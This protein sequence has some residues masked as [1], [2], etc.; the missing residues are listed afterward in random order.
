MTL[1]ARL[2]R[3]ETL[4]DRVIKVDHAGEYGAICIYRAQRW[5]AHWRAPDMIGELD[6]FLDHE[7][8]HR[9]RFG[10]EL[11]RRNRRRCRSYHLCGLG[12]FILGVVTGMA[13]RGA[14]AATTVAIERVVLRHMSAQIEALVGKDE[15]A[16]ALLRQIIV[17]ERE[18]HDVS[19]VRLNP[20]F[21]P[22]LLNPLV[23]V[24]TEAVIWLGMRL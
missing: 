7:L 16:V 13:G 2:D 14:I 23:S 22:K 4:G 11:G 17:E 6:R 9:A 20:L 3:D 10:A 24:S 15:E 5:F 1:A 18:H 12:G 8:G 21:W 19:A